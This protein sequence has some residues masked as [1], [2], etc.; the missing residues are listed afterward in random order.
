MSEVS[1]FFKAQIT[2]VKAEILKH[3]EALAAVQDGSIQS[4]TFSTGQTSQTV[5]RANLS[6]LETTIEK[7]LNRLAVLDARVNGAARLR[8]TP[9]W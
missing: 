1:D 2:A 4:Y 5:T 8:V 7:L 9:G 3:Q 6:T